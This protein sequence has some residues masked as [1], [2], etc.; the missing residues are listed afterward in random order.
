MALPDSGPPATNVL[1]VATHGVAVGVNVTLTP[2]CIA[3]LGSMQAMVA[4]CA[5]LP[6][7]VA[8]WT[9]PNEFVAAYTVVG[10][11]QAHVLEVTAC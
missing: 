10:P 1:T 9:Q 7:V 6:L 4:V 8:A 5:Q 3:A 11:T 2:T